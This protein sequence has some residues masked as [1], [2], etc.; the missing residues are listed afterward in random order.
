MLNCGEVLPLPTREV[1]KAS[2]LEVPVQTTVQGLQGESCMEKD[3][4]AE[5]EGGIVEVI[6]VK[7]WTYWENTF[8]ARSHYRMQIWNYATASKNSTYHLPSSVH[9]TG[10]LIKKQKNTYEEFQ[11]LSWQD[12]KYLSLFSLFPFKAFQRD[13]FHFILDIK[14]LLAGFCEQKCRLGKW[15]TYSADTL[16]AFGRAHTKLISGSKSYIIALAVRNFF[17]EIQ[18]SLFF[19]N[20]LFQFY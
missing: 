12:M 17:D 18:C 1:D 3:K 5:E 2:Y 16:A 8:E 7:V 13:G 10:S 14:H 11:L 9:A 6:P 19:K 15:R 4:D 20:V